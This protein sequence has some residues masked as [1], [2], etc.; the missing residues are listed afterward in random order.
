MSEPENFP[1]PVAAAATSAAPGEGLVAWTHVIYALHAVTV[2]VGAMTAAFIVTV[3]VF[4]VPSIVA[5][6]LSYVK[7]GEA[8]GTFLESHFR[9]LIRTFWFSALWCFIG[10]LLMITVIGIPIA[11]AL[12]VGVGLW[13]VYRLIRGWLALGNARPLPI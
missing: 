6:I 2:L 4:S 11:F 8:T 7:R 5:M 12:F 1:Q 10:G 3:F 13:V 9:W